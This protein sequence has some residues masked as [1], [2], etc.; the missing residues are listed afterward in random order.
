MKNLKQL[1]IF[2]FFFFLFSAF[3]INVQLTRE[4]AEKAIRE[5]VKFSNSSAIGQKLSILEVTSIDSLKQSS[6]TEASCWITAWGKVENSGK[7]SFPIACMHIK[8]QFK[9]EF[10]FQ[11]KADK[12]LL[13]HL[14]RFATKRRVS[15]EYM[16]KFHEQS[17]N[18]N[19][20]AQ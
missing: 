19:I 18:L 15:P 3:Y 5:F 11:K 20:A 2:L 16:Q 14:D 6:E 8:A 12:W 1:S 13:T 17:G 4:G 9:M 10:L 7:D